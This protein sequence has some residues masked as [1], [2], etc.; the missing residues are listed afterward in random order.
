MRIGQKSVLL[1]YKELP[2]NQHA[3][4]ILNQEVVDGVHTLQ[5]S[6]ALELFKVLYPKSQITK[7]Q[8]LREF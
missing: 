8:I 6:A 5:I 1:I 7:G 4:K 3:K 2:K